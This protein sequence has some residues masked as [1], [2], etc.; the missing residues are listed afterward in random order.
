MRIN[1]TGVGH[2]T[3]PGAVFGHE[4]G[5]GSTDFANRPIRWTENEDGWQNI[6]SCWPWPQEPWRQNDIKLPDGWRHN[7]PFICQTNPLPFVYDE[8]YNTKWGTNDLMAGLRLGWL[9]SHLGRDEMQ[10]LTVV[11]VGC[12]NGVFVKCARN[13]FKRVAGYNVCGESISRDELV[14]EHWGLVVLTDVLEHMPDIRAL[15]AIHWEYAMISIPETPRVRSFDELMRWRHFKPNE[16]IWLLDWKGLTCW[17]L[18]ME[19]GVCPIAVSDFEDLIR[20]RWDSQTTNISTL[21]VR[22]TLRNRA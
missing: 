2:L 21:L 8:N 19:P 18:N 20:T 4:G 14:S 13:K 1:L 11:D 17:A 10:R 7:G 12:G 3:I 5:P 6:P 9:A 15:F 22:R 16:H